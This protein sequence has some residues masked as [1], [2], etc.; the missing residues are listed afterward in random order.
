MRRLIAGLDANGR[1]CVVKETRMDHA[2]GGADREGVA[3]R[4]LYQTTTAPLPSRPP[5]RSEFR[6]LAV[7]PGCTQWLVSRWGPHERAA[8]HHT[9]T[10]DF[11]LVV[12]GTMELILDD[13]A[14][15]L[16]PGDCAVITGV[17]HGW[18]AGPEGCTLSVVLVGS[19]PPDAVD[20]R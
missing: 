8:P 2:V 13:G 20:E 7:R 6:D 17:D 3:V 16:E 18:R 4:S 14:H 9:D 11:D 12:A 10:L 15:L 5:G 19:P 1:S